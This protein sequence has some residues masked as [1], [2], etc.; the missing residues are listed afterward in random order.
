MARN[1]LGHVEK[2]SGEKKPWKKCLRMTQ[3]ETVLLE[4]QE[5]DGQMA[6]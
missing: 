1:L 4:I 5:R 6:F 2:M 3:R